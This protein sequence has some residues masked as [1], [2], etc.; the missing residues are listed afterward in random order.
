MPAIITKKCQNVVDFIEKYRDGWV[1]RERDFSHNTQV[2]INSDGSFS[3]RLWST[4]IVEFIKSR[5]EYV[6]KNWGRWTRTTAHDIRAYLE[7]LLGYRFDR[8]DIF[9][10][11]WLK[12]TPEDYEV[13]YGT[14][15]RWTFNP[16]NLIFKWDEDG[17]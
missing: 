17:E 2:S 11:H 1:Y 9:T 16:T 13:A 6:I 12:I 4:K 15:R 8:W 10:D 5:N 3:I 7:L 14:D